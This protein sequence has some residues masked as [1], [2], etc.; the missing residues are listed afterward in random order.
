[1]PE[2]TGVNVSVYNIKLEMYFSEFPF[3]P[4]G[5]FPSI[6]PSHRLTIKAGGAREE[7]IH[8]DDEWKSPVVVLMA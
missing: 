4:V 8:R 2:G 1:M 6:K 7:V 5:E 3:Q